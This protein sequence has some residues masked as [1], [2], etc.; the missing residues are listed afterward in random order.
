M[1]EPPGVAVRIATVSMVIYNLKTSRSQSIWGLNLTVREETHATCSIT[2]VNPRVTDSASPGN[3]PRAQ[4]GQMSHP[5]REK[6]ITVISRMINREVDG[7][8]VRLCSQSS[9]RVQLVSFY[10][11]N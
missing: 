6:I 10:E 7:L 5:Q 1:D 3:L 8:V 4:M 11:C 9:N 2:D